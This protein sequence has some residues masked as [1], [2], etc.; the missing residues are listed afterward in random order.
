MLTDGSSP[1]RGI[2]HSL[3]LGSTTDRRAKT[4]LVVDGLLAIDWIDGFR[5]RL[6]F[7][8]WAFGLL[9]GSLCHVSE[10]P[11][12]FCILELKDLHLQT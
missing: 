7:R 1:R 8:V 12:C 10:L 3:S 11:F 6:V 5:R 9:G 2:L 4:D